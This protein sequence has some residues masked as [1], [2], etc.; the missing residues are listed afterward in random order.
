MTLERIVA[1]LAVHKSTVSRAIRDK[2]LLAPASCFLLR[3]MFTT[4][5]VTG[6]GNEKG[7]S[8]NTIKE[9]LKAPTEAEDKQR[10][11]SDEQLAKSLGEAGMAVSRRTVAKYRTKLGIRGTFKRREA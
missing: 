7:V 2:Y 11:Y 1:E 3:D 4:G 8:R 6:A 5:I 9:K 10:P